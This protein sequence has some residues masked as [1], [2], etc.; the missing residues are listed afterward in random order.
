MQSKDVSSG[1]FDKLSLS[2]AWHEHSQHSSVHRVGNV[3]ASA[4]GLCKLLCS[5]NLIIR[6]TDLIKALC[7]TKG[8][9]LHKCT[10]SALAS[11]AW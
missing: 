7:V 9:G 2:M 10:A 8:K 6:S 1:R 5:Q 11:L 4:R 3:N